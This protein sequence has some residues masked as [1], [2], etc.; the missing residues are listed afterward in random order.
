MHVVA[1]LMGA[2]LFHFSFGESVKYKSPHEV[3]QR[4]DKRLKSNLY[5]AN[6]TIIIFVFVLYCIVL[7]FIVLHRIVLYCIV[8][9]CIVLYC[10]VLYCIV[11][12]SLLQG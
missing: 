1:S 5:G 6:D 8:L 10:I 11:L 12:T 3:P 2:Y 7:Y 9:Y 4:Q